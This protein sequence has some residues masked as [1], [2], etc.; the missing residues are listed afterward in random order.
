VLNFDNADIEAVIQAASEIGKFNCT[1]GPG[2]SGKKVTVQ[3]SGRIPEDEVFNVLLAVLEINGV[4]MIR[5]G[6]LYKI[7]PLAAARSARSPPSS[8]PSR[9]PPARRRDDHPDRAPHLRP[10]GPHRATIR[11]F[12]QGGNVVVH[13]SLLIVTDTAGISPDCSGLS[14]SSTSR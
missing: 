5:S 12:V 4:T 7:V 9:N 3:T 11:P 13:G 1:I 2:V 10:G 14:G 6:N 8:A